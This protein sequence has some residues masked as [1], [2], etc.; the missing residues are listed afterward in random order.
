MSYCSVEYLK[1]KE[2]EYKQP[3]DDKTTICPECGGQP[4]PLE[5]LFAC[6]VCGKVWWDEDDADQCCEELKERG[7]KMPERACGPECPL[8]RAACGPWAARVIRVC[9]VPIEQLEAKLAAIESYRL[10]RELADTYRAVI[11]ARR[12]AEANTE[13]EGEKA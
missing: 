7:S 9:G 1:C 3:D 4:E 5:D 10:P 2:C 8:W 11:A 12:A 13:G 6:G